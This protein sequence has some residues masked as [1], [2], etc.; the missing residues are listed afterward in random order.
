[1]PP[2]IGAVPRWGFQRRRSRSAQPAS[3]TSSSNA[4]SAPNSR[5]AQPKTTRAA[6]LQT[7]TVPLPRAGGSAARPVQVDARQQQVERG[8]R[9]EILPRRTIGRQQSALLFGQRS[10]RL[11][12]TPAAFR[13]PAAA[14]ASRSPQPETRRASRARPSTQC[15]AAPRPMQP[16]RRRRRSRPHRQRAG[17]AAA[18]HAT[19]HR[20][21]APPG[22]DAEV[23]AQMRARLAFQPGEAE[24]ESTGAPSPKRE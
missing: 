2:R 6:S 19:Q 22:L 15:R 24:P 21:D 17:T 7:C 14:V 13:P 23:F 1:M 8:E 9:M 10:R 18:A 3:E 16:M 12:A 11:P 4:A 5:V 20:D